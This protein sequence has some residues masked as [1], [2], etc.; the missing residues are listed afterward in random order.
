MPAR[1]IGKSRSGRSF[2]VR[3]LKYRKNR[4]RGMSQYDA[5][6][7]AGY[8]ESTARVSVVRTERLVKASIIDELNRAGATDKYIAEQLAEIAHSATRLHLTKAAREEYPDYRVRKDTLELM[9]KLKRHVS[10][11]PTVVEQNQTHITVVLATANVHAQESDAGGSDIPPHTKT[12]G[13]VP[14]PDVA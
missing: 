1:R 12:N 3:Q 10:D 8:A 4:L 5:A 7:A 14:A 13:R 11:D 6:I 9:T 2:T